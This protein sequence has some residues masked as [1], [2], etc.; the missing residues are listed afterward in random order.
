VAFRWRPPGLPDDEVDRL[1][2]ELLERINARRRVYLTATRLDGRFVIRI[3][4]LSFRTH[5]DRMEAA[6]EDIRAALAE[7]QA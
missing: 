2:R 6:L 7:L 4:V 1:N 3:C 5:H